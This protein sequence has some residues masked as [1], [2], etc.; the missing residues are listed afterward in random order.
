MMLR[1]PTRTRI[2]LRLSSAE[3]S[4]KYAK[5]PCDGVALLSAESSARALGI[6]PRKL[7]ANGGEEKYLDLFSR[8]IVRVARDFAPRPV[9]Y[10]TLDMN[11]KECAA[12]EGGAEYEES[13]ENPTR[14]LCGCSRYLADEAS[15]R[16]DLRAVKRARDMGCVNVD[17]MLPFARCADEL[18]RCREIVIE[19]GLFASAE[20]ELWMMAAVPATELPIEEFLP[21][22]FGV[23]IDPE[24]LGQ[25]VPGVNGGVGRRPDPS[26][27][28]HPTVLA[29]MTLIA[30]AC[31]EHGVACSIC[32]NAPILH[33]RPQPEGRPHMI[34]AL[35]E[36][37]VTGWN[38]APDMYDEA[39]EA[40]ANAESALGISPERE[41]AK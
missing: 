37:G 35:L 1:A 17:V 11:L 2:S 13:E 28:C 22:V 24:Y 40:I 14:G 3:L 16:L 34:R 10:R 18:A 27:E 36:A 38:V 25:L 21:L 19:E 20:F 8:N 6:H 39:V 33:P 30:R 5:L 41:V 4:P 9:V 32:G 29:A 7:L 23:S 15:F 31:R 12:L 26:D